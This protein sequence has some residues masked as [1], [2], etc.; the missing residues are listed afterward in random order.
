MMNMSKGAIKELLI[1]DVEKFKSMAKNLP[2]SEKSVIIKI[3]QKR[4]EGMAK[5]R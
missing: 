4:V 1:A 2:S 5:I 3:L